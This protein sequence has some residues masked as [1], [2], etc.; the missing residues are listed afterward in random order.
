MTD[1]YGAPK[2]LI[3]G[4]LSRSL[5]LHLSVKDVAALGQKGA[6]KLQEVTVLSG[7]RGN[8]EK[9]GAGGIAGVAS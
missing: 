5:V 1:P 6:G 2:W 4:Q 9:T 8:G 3:T 7:R